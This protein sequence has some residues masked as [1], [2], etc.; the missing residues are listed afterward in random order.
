MQAESKQFTEYDITVE[1]M[2]FGAREKCPRLLS[3]TDPGGLYPSHGGQV[4][5]LRTIR[6][7]HRGLIPAQQAC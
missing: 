2:P 5:T 1:A 3:K 7:K 6:Q 4:S